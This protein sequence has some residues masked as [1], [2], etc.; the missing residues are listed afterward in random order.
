MTSCYFLF[1]HRRVWRKET[2]AKEMSR[3]KGDAMPIGKSGNHGHAR[4]IQAGKRE[5]QNKR[6]WKMQREAERKWSMGR[7]V[8][9][10]VALGKMALAVRA[11][12]FHVSC[13]V[14]R[15]HVAI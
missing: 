7:E 4:S 14:K 13:L 6:T 9:M 1:L 2:N 12:S 5:M 15:P 3:P 10:K 11:P 8:V